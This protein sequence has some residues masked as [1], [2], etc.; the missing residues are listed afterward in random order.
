MDSVQHALTHLKPKFRSV[1]VLRL[2]DGYSVRETGVILGIPEGTVLSR[3]ARAQKRLREL[4]SPMV[5]GL[6]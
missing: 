4:L 6:L 2:I 3:F 5:K 1:V